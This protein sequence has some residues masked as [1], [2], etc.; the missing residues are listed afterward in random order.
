VLHDLASARSGY[1]IDADVVVIGSGPGGV[2]AADNLAA[3]GMR[4][5]VVEA[6]PEVKREDMLRAPPSVLARNYWEGGLRL[7]G[8]SSPNPSMQGRCLGGSTVVNSAIMLPL[9]EHVRQEWAEGDGLHALLTGPGAQALERAFAR[10]FER[11]HTAPTPMAVMG[12]RNLV[13]RDALVAMG[14]G[15]GPLPRAVSGCEASANCI[16]GCAPGA[17]QS[18]DR[19]YLPAVV[20]RGGHVFTCS[21][22][23]KILVERGRAAGVSG[24]V[25]DPDG[26]REVG[27]FTVRAPRVVV[28]AGAGQT[29]A[30]LLQSGLTG[31]GRVGKSLYAHLSGV[32]VGVMPE[33]V[34]PWHG[35]T[36]GWG[37]ISPDHPG[38]KFEALWAPPC[39]IT[40]GWGSVGQS[41]VET[42][43]ATRYSSVM[44]LVYKARVSGGVTL[45]LGGLPRMRLDIPVSEAHMV[46]RGLKLAVEGM[47]AAGATSVLTTVHHHVPD[48]MTRPSDAEALLSPKLRPHDFTMTFNHIFGS[49]RMSA[50]PR[51]GPVDARG[52]LRGVEG[53]WVSDASIFPGPSAVNPQATI[54]ALS[55]LISRGIGGVAA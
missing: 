22:V 10:V 49:C 28:A 6:G 38:M 39:L 52:A 30:L 20:A 2:V 48:R 12:R 17:K 47:L 5:V 13:V 26:W 36:Q 4:V 24:R 15:G 7:V 21:Q 31:G 27:R 14:Q 44:A 19:S 45:G 42:L 33:P 25:I 11:T 3:A 54:M 16:T 35:A 18:V 1:S 37:A 53:V 40:A 51:R 46:A 23:D 34:E 9:P 43:A 50:D 55:D 32:V 29:P 41:F 8:G